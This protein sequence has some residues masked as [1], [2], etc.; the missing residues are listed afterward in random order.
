MKKPANRMMRKV[1]FVCLGFIVGLLLLLSQANS[2]FATMPEE[3]DPPQ[4]PVPTTWVAGETS[5]SDLTVEQQAQLC[6]VPLDKLPEIREQ[7]RETAPAM[8]APTYGYPASIDWRD[9]AGQDWTTPIRNQRA[10]G[11][12]VA[13]GVIGSIESRMEIAEDNALL[14][15]DLSEAHLFFCG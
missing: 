9:M 8:L 13:F 7:A 1:T 14:S 10:C 15:P 11:S 4:P 3:A 6:G 5:V 12:C 2:A